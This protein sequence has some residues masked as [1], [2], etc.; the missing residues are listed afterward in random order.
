MAT[1]TQT[2]EPLAALSP[3]KMLVVAEH[4]ATLGGDNLRPYVT[5][6]TRAF[7][8]GVSDAPHGLE[9]YYAWGEELGVE[10]RHAF[11]PRSRGDDQSQSSRPKTKSRP[12]KR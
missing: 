5:A 9:K 3:L 4:Q 7:Q 6:M 12:S 2:W 11:W 8:G 10:I 1:S